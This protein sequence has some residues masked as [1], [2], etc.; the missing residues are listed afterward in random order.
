MDYKSHSPFLGSSGLLIAA[1]IL[2]PCSRWTH[3]TRLIGRGHIPL[4]TL[5]YKTPTA[6]FAPVLGFKGCQGFSKWQHMAGKLNLVLTKLY[7][8]YPL[9]HQWT[10]HA[11]LVLAL[12]PWKHLIAGDQS[13]VQIGSEL[14]WNW[15]NVIMHWAYPLTKVYSLKSLTSAT[16]YEKAFKWMGVGLQAGSRAYWSN[17]THTPHLQTEGL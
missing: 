9:S 8:F 3:P 10:Q 11:F 12:C 5:L 2:W 1:F 6:G 15:E 7:R 4:D 16:L 13:H 14:M 17:H